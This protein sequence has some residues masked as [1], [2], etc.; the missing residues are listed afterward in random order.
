[1][2]N[3]V[4]LIDAENRNRLRLYESNGNGSILNPLTWTEF[5]DSPSTYKRE[6]QLEIRFMTALLRQLKDES[7]FVE[8]QET[9][10]VEGDYNFEDAVN[11]IINRGSVCLKTGVLL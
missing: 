6:R 1:M 3:K 9:F 7:K 4:I 2:K 8:F 10:D 11:W 5:K